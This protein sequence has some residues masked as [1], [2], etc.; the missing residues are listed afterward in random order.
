MNL[1]DL[2]YA[3]GAVVAFSAISA[4]ASGVIVGGNTGASLTYLFAIIP[5]LFLGIGSSSPG[6]IVAA[7]NLFKI[8]FDSEFQSRRVHHEAAHFLAGYLCGLPIKSYTVDGATTQI[9][10]FDTAE[11]DQAV[12]GR[13]L[14]RP[15]IDPVS[16]VALA[17]AVAEVKKF[18]SA[19]GSAQDLDSLGRLM[20]RTSPPMRDQA[21]EDQTRWAA[22]TAHKL[23]G[24]Y[25]KEFSALV[26]AFS[27]KK[28]VAE[29][30]A[31]LETVSD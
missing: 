31:A 15:E 14:T 21:Q 6:I 24:R 20:N 10:F 3:L 16:V 22:L 1:D 28:S 8:R 2:K 9:E 19:T 17:G 26:T 23:L 27:E 12:I 4:V 7:I 30:I 25:E 5:I 29:C 11:G 18:G 13:Q